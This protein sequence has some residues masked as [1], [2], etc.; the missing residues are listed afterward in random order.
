MI[1]SNTGKCKRGFTLVELLVVIAIVAVLVAVSVSA[2]FRFRKSADKTVALSNMRQI[3]TANVSYAADHSSRFVSPVDS[4][5][6]VSYNW[7]EN[8]DFVSQLK[9]SQAT[10]GSGGTVDTTLPITLM[11]PA[12]VKKREP[13][14]Q[15]LSGSYAYNTE[16]MPLVGGVKK[17]FGLPLI[18]DPG[19]TAAFIT[20]ASSAGG[21]VD[22]ASANGIAYRHDDKAIVVYYDGHAAPVSQS[23]VSGT[24]GGATGAFWDANQA[25][26]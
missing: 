24:N 11:D 9:S 21:V 12:V 17:G 25:D 10:Y 13:G 23:E 3:Q 19:R 4:V 18:G 1:L 16:G 22:Y 8:P 14:F 20:A 5:N 15:I 6:S 7:W 26:N 2:V